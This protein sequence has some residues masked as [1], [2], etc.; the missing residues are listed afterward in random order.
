M[1]FELIWESVSEG[2]KNTTYLLIFPMTQELV[3][4]RPLVWIDDKLKNRYYREATYEALK[5]ARK[6][7]SDI[8]C[9]DLTG[10]KCTLTHFEIEKF[11]QADT[12]DHYLFFALPKEDK[13]IQRQFHITI[14]NMSKKQRDELTYEKIRRWIESKK[15]EKKYYAQA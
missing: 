9:Q 8:D 3:E 10:R 6:A 2:T 7:M 4:Q 11:W 13:D 15:Q 12:V 14:S 1:A 5:N